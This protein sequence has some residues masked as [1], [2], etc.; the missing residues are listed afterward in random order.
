MARIARLVLP[1]HP[2]HITQRGNR[3]QTTFFNAADY[4][5]YIALVARGAEAAEVGVLAYCLMPNHVHFIV[6]PQRKNSLAALF[7][8]AHRR[9]TRRI[10]EREKWCGH[11]WQARFHSAALDEQHLLAAARYV[12]LNPVRATMCQQ[13]QEWP[14]SSARAHLAGINDALVDV[15]PMLGRVNN[16][17]EYLG[18]EVPEQHI[19]AIR[20]NTRSGRS[21]V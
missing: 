15:A 12:E 3:R 6:V 18:A 11:L 17:R 10:N 9:Y 20:R 19:E 21:F 16:W 1:G 5:A 8:E 14:W 13:P 2:H 4:R 7:S